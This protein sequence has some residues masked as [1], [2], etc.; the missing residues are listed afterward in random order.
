MLSAWR[1]LSQTLWFYNVDMHSASRVSGIISNHLHLR[2]ARLVRIAAGRFQKLLKE[3]WREQFYTVNG[4]YYRQQI[5]QKKKRNMQSLPWLKLIR[6]AVMEIF[7]LEVKENYMNMLFLRAAMLSMVEQP[8][9]ITVTEELLLLNEKH[10]GILDFGDV[11]RVKHWNAQA[12]SDCG[13]WKDAVKSCKSLIREHEQHGGYPY[14]LVFIDY[15]RALYELRKYDEAIEVGNMGIKVRRYQSGVHKYVALSQ[16][17]NGDI[18]EAKMTMAR[19]ILYEY[20]WDEDNL[21]KNKQM[22]RE[23]SSL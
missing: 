16:K 15:S 5:I 20:H 11:S 8:E 23:L 14:A 9:A 17:A 13:K 1:K 3:P 7:D 6:D 18:D 21:Q 12:Y 19:A 4:Q 10:P 2:K 22:L